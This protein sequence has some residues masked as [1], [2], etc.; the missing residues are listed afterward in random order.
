LN[1]GHEK[2]EIAQEQADAVAGVGIG[3]RGLEGAGDEAGYPEY[4]GEIEERLAADEFE[5]TISAVI[6]STEAQTV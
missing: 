6:F 4:D 5:V 2:H 1:N 3:G